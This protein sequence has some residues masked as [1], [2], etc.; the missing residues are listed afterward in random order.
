LK[1]GLH[2]SKHHWDNKK[3]GDQA[4]RRSVTGGDAVE[5]K[6]LR[7]RN[8]AAERFYTRFQPEGAEDPWESHS[9][10]KLETTVDQ[11]S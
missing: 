4:E 3:E 6:I 1:S 9:L 7:Q 11:I 8:A 2:Y 5:I 10:E